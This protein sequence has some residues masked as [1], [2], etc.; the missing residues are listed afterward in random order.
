V[1]RIVRRRLIAAC[2][3]LRPDLG[4]EDIHRARTALKKARAALRMLRTSLGKHRFRRENATLREI[5]H[6]FTPSRDATTLVQTLDALHPSTERPSVEINALHRHLRQRQAQA[7][8]QW[9]GHPK[10][11]EELRSALHALG[12]R[13]AHWRVEKQGWSV[14]DAA[15]RRSY[16]R[17]QRA[18]EEVLLTR[19]SNTAMDQIAT[20]ERLHAWR[21]QAKV[22]GYQLRLLRP[23]APRRVNALTEALREL[24]QRLGSDHDLA[25]LRQMAAGTS[26]ATDT[27]EAA[28]VLPRDTLLRDIDRLRERLQQEARARGRVLYRSTPKRFVA[29]LEPM[30]RAWRG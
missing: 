2:E 21:K 17:G 1:R 12:R 29:Q 8:Q 19:G 6:R 30:W 14:L 4:D 28:E 25:L 23:M 18:F 26:L 3:A 22:L 27:A 7:R 15:L 24:T 5:A 20:D 16:R 9:A 13:A 11:L 10:R